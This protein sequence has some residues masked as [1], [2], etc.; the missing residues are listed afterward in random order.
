MSLFA[1]PIHFPV[2]ESH[3][4]V[5]IWD[6]LVRDFIRDLNCPLWSSISGVRRGQ[7]R[8]NSPVTIIITSKC[9]SQIQ[10]YETRI[11]Q[12]IRENGLS[13]IEVAFLEVEDLFSNG[14]DTTALER[15]Q[16]PISYATSKALYMGASVG[17]KDDPICSGTIGGH[18]ILTYGSKYDLGVTNCHVVS[19]EKP[20]Q[21]MY[22]CS[23]VWLP[24]RSTNSFS[25]F[26][27]DVSSIHPYDRTSAGTVLVSPSDFDQ[28]FWN[29]LFC[30][31]LEAT[32]GRLES[33]TLKYG[34]EKLDD[35]RQVAFRKLQGRISMYKKQ[36]KLYN[37]LV[38]TI[39]PVF[40]QVRI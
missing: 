8:A 15:T 5:P 33:F 20:E 14:N 25:S 35:R 19:L 23:V 11:I 1:P 21:G 26:F 2:E 10:Q 7:E 13:G 38:R 40:Q 29:K 30:K 3:P 28:K 6:R 16:P 31:N 22:I 4:I 12:T 18:I 37:T 34:T 32:E 24:L 27:A 17:V 9:P 36:L 39:G